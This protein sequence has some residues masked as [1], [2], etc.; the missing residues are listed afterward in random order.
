MKKSLTVLMSQLFDRCF[1]STNH[2]RKGKISNL[3]HPFARFL[4]NIPQYE[5]QEQD[6]MNYDNIL[7][8]SNLLGL[9]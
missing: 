5:K 7:I 1:G 9:H 4:I 3:F 8:A 2:I 6:A